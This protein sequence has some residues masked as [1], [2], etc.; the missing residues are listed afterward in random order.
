MFVKLNDNCHMT[1]SLDFTGELTGLSARLSARHLQGC[2][3][4]VWPF[5]FA[6][7]RR[8]PPAFK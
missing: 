3:S 7:E 4:P 8:S 5:F 6:S 2:T 1:V